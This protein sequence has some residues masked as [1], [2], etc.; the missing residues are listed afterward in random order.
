[1]DK[2]SM[3]TESLLNALDKEVISRER[4]KKFNSQYKSLVVKGWIKKNEYSIPLKDTIGN[5][6]K[7]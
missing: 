3:L 5:I 7:I 1:M 2:D 6:N 4:L